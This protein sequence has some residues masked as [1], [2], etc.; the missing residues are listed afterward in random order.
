MKHM[1][2]VRTEYKRSNWYDAMRFDPG[3]DNVLSER[4]NKRHTK[5][6]SQM[7]AGVSCTRWMSFSEPNR[8]P[9]RSLA[10]MAAHADTPLVVQDISVRTS[11]ASIEAAIYSAR[12]P[13]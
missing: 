4:N 11:T 12:Y 13:A 10:R 8:T 6:R 3:R 2:N 9:V 1:L 5:L 7:A